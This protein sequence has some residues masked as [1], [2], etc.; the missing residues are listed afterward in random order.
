M[1]DLTA[2]GALR[3]E[4]RTKGR[5]FLYTRRYTSAL[6]LAT[7]SLQA[8]WLKFWR[9]DVGEFTDRA[10]FG[11]GMHKDEF[12]LKRKLLVT[13]T[14]VS[15]A[16]GLLLW[17]TIRAVGQTDSDSKDLPGRRVLYDRSL[18]DFKYRSLLIPQDKFTW[19][20]VR[21]L[22]SE[23]LG[24]LTPDVQFAE[25][26]IAY[27]EAELRKSSEGL[28]ELYDV[29]RSISNVY[30][31][32][33]DKYGPDPIVSS[34]G[35]ARVFYLRGSALLSFRQPGAPRNDRPGVREV[36]LRGKTDP[37]RIIWANRPYRLLHVSV[38]EPDNRGVYIFLRSD[39]DTSC[40]ECLA[41]ARSFQSQ[42]SAASAEVQI[43]WDS[44]FVSPYFPLSFRFDSDME[45]FNDTDLGHFIQPPS[46]AT[47]YRRP[48]VTCDLRSCTSYGLRERI[49][50]GKAVQ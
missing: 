9:E 28:P 1:E 42:F 46:V 22:G 10:I 27:S 5:P 13:I 11:V 21:E 39:E 16:G 12:R 36:L 14:V 32:A 48:H 2:K 45:P 3:S 40:S 20:T 30:Q 33:R 25:L 35:I 41:L 18:R 4:V 17:Q 19:E 34:N 7:D 47:Y 37:T 29:E 49:P 44:W 50:P 8:I 43:R 6:K 15:G 31:R 23:F 26:L 38:G 24:E